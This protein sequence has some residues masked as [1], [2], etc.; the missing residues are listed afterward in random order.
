MSWTRWNG[1]SIKRKIRE[2][3]IN[4]V[5]KT[6]DVVLSASKQEVPL[7]DGFLLRSGIVVLKHDNVPVAIIS[8]GGG[9]G[10]GHPQ[11]PYARRWHE[12][13]ANF[14]HGRKWKYLKDPFNR[15]ASSSLTRIL[16]A[17]LRRIL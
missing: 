7:D 17:E 4:T 12:N 9:P 5:V 1:P 14:Q 2:A 6:G 15:L 3:T 11:I 8:F 10:T 13:Q 16:E